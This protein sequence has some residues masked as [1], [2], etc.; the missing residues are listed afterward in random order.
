MPANKSMVQLSKG[1]YC[2]L[3]IELI[4]VLTFKV[5]FLNTEDKDTFNKNKF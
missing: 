3:E 4:I 5:V 2:Y 1:W